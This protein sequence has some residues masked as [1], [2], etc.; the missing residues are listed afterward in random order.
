MRSD[1]TLEGHG[2]VPPT[3]KLDNSGKVIASGNTDD[4]VL[5]L[6]QVAAITN[7]VD[8]PSN[9]AN[10]WYARGK[11]TLMLPPV[12]VSAGT[13]EHSWGESESDATPDLVN[14]VRMTFHDVTTPGAVSMSLVGRDRPGIPALP[15]WDAAVSVYSYSSTAAVTGGVDVLIRYDA[16]D[17]VVL[18][19][20]EHSLR[21]LAY[22]GGWQNVA[23]TAFD[24]AKNLIGGHFAAASYFVIAGGTVTLQFQPT[25]NDLPVASVTATRLHFEPVMPGVPEPAIS[26]ILVATGGMIVLRRRRSRA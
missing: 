6:T 9:G 25:Q 5:D 23:L 13:S 17:S 4:P 15:A 10:G 20:G 18:T 21:L 8:N 2:V 22:D 7:S 24:P 11:A 14:S 19:R 16:L 1:T 26:C 3:E 12:P